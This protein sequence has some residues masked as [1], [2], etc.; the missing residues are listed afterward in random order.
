MHIRKW[1]WF[2][3][4]ENTFDFFIIAESPC[5]SSFAST[6]HTFHPHNRHLF[7][8]RIFFKF[9]IF[10]SNPLQ[11]QPLLTHHNYKEPRQNLYQ[12]VYSISHLDKG[13]VFIFRNLIVCMFLNNPITMS[14]VTANTFITR[15]MT[16]SKSPNTCDLLTAFSIEDKSFSLR[17]IKSV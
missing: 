13:M 6:S 17:A 14:F 8:S 4:L 16:R 11:N 3:Q 9:P 1:K 2:E 5:H 10:F 12:T 7:W 15:L